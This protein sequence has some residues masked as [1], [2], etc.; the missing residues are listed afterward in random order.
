MELCQF[1]TV[2]CYL[3]RIPMR[4]RMHSHTNAKV[5]VWM[6]W[7]AG[8]NWLYL[9]HHMMLSQSHLVVLDIDNTTCG[10]EHNMGTEQHMTDEYNGQD[11]VDGEPG[12]GHCIVRKGGDIIAAQRLMLRHD[13]A[14]PCDG[15]R[16]FVDAC[17]ALGVDV[18][19]LTCRD[20]SLRPETLAQLSRAL[21]DRPDGTPKYVDLVMAGEGS[22]KGGPL[23]EWIRKRPAPPPSHVLFVD[24]KQGHLESVARRM[25]YG[26]CE[27]LTAVL[28]VG[29]LQRTIEYNAAYPKRRRVMLQR[30]DALVRPHTE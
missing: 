12:Y 6:D 24:D 21:G 18:L 19:M 23:L 17:V 22:R 30:W 5:H 16:E 4:T 15:V 13:P 10:G 20:P 29:Q 1:R 3:Y 11:E 9:N 7:M 27:S 25:P 8:L 2:H 14:G 26:L 28:Y